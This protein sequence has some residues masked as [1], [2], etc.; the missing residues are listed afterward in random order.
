M[1][2]IGWLQFNNSL[3]SLKLIGSDNINYSLKF[4]SSLIPTQRDEGC[5]DIGDVV[6][7]GEPARD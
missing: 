6:E 7:I 5:L 1:I 3:Q 4:W 2:T